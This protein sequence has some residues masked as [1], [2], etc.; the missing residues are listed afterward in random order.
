M[1]FH[2]RNCICDNGQTPDVGTIVMSS[3]DATYGPITTKIRCSVV[4][5]R[6]IAGSSFQVKISLCA[7]KEMRV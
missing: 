3:S 2:E 1:T 4:V 7:E 5:E 6:V